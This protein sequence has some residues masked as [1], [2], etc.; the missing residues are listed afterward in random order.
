MKLPVFF[1]FEAMTVPAA[2]LLASPWRRVRVTVLPWR[3][4]QVKVV[5]L[6]VERSQPP[7][8]VSKAFGPWAATSVERLA[9]ARKRVEKKRM[10]VKV[11]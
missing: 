11:I 5:A 2:R 6:A 10:T 9:R 3:F 4:D 7:V 1:M 8:G